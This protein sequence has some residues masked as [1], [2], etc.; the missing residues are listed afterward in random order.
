MLYLIIC[1]SSLITVLS[2][3]ADEVY[4]LDLVVLFKSDARPFRAA[5]DFAV[6]LDREAFGREREMLY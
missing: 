1:H 2:S 5:H 3:A 6:A 4:D